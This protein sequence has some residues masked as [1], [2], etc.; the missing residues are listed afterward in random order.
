L[1]RKPY[2]RYARST[3][4][5][6]TPVVLYLLG[7]NIL[8][9]LLQL[10]F[11][12]RY[13]GV[14][15][16]IPARVLGKGYVW[17]VVTYL[18]LHADPMHILFNMLF[19]WM[20]GSELERYWGGKEFIKYY[21]IT[22]CGAGLVNVLVQPGLTRPIIGASGAIFGLIV[23]FALAFPDREI[24]F[25]FMIRMKAKYFA[26]LAVLI[27]VFALWQMPN[28]PVARFAHLGGLLVGY[29]Y[30]KRER[31]TYGLRKRIASFRVEVAEAR[32]ARIRRQRE[33][34]RCEMDRILD[35]IS[36]RG[37]DSLTDR[38]RRFL[39]K[40]SRGGHEAP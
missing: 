23:G 36:S 6:T 30:L 29:L 7:A 5:G 11:L 12:N 4:P 2:E 13:L 32:D 20:L 8:I 22:G 1:Y 33:N 26:L 25:L 27:E 40:R 14:L 38:E 9:F 18:F 39:K 15:G 16:L 37:M 10:G 24:L 21:F 34:T 35:K 28:A 3:V 31:L 19:L 17:Q